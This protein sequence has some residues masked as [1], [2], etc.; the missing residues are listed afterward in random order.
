VFDYRTSPRWLLDRAFWQ[1]F[2]KRGME[3]HVPASSDEETAFLGALFYTFV[4]SRA[5][6]L[7]RRPSLAGVAQFLALFVFT[8]AVGAGY[9][10]GRWVWG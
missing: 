1:G 6:G 8:T 4:P 5:K 3:V 9:A 10:Y 7:V 2:S